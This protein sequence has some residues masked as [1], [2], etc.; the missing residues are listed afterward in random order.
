ML[1]L[2]IISYFAVVNATAYFLMFWDKRKAIKQQW[3]IPEKTLLLLCIL[4]G[5]VGIG[6]GMKHFRHKTLHFS[7][8]FTVCFSLLLYCLIAPLTLYR[9]NL[10]PF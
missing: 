1:N 6:L 2:L 9:L 4:G 10:L 8:K 3:R 7:F 5:F